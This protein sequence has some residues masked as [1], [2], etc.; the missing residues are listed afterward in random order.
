[1]TDYKI[2]VEK[3]SKS[4]LLFLLLL[5]CLLH[6]PDQTHHPTTKRELKSFVSRKS[7]RSV[8]SEKQKRRAEE[9]EEAAAE[10]RLAEIRRK[11]EEKKKRE[12]E[13]KRKKEEEEKK[14]G[15]EEEEQERKKKEIEQV[16]KEKKE[17]EEREKEKR[18]EENHTKSVG[19]LVQ[20]SIA[21]RGKRDL[22]ID[23]DS[24]EVIGKKRKRVAM[25]ASNDDSE[26][27]E[28]NPGDDGE[29]SN[30]ESDEYEDEK[31]DEEE[32]EKALTPTPTPT[33]RMPSKCNRCISKNA[34]SKVKCSLVGNERTVR[35]SKRLRRED[36]IVASSSNERIDALEESNR[37]LSRRLYL[38]E[39]MVRFIVQTIQLV[40]A[41]E[42][43]E[44][45]WVK[46]TG[47]VKGKGR[48]E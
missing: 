8:R 32:S 6:H 26:G 42:E 10:A 21:R 15:E 13:E 33:P 48:K 12:A 18:E 43:L 20:A 11:R 29:D 41:D 4:S 38:M 14:K 34:S 7:G 28:H 44:E 5:P 47:D 9:E 16:V 40:D 35:R 46:R 30:P 45:D 19:A 37:E 39:D 3:L 31:G 27:N 23:V 2:N 36:S 1:M 25:I 24:V 22:P 17:K